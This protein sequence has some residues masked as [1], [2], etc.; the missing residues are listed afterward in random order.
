MGLKI[1]RSKGELVPTAEELPNT[2]A[3]ALKKFNALFGSLGQFFVDRDSELQQIKM[4]LLTKEHVLLQGTPGTAKSLLARSVFQNVIGA[5]RYEVQFSKFMSEDY[6]FGPVNIK[7]L[8]EDG[9]I[10][11]NTKGTIVDSDFAFIDE[12]FDGSD[13]LLRSM[14]EILNERTFT[15][16]SKRVECPLHTAILTSNYTRE[17]EATGAILDRILFKSSVQPISDTDGRMTM[18]KAALDKKNSC[19][20]EAI[21]QV[22]LNT[23]AAFVMSGDVKVSNDVLTMY[24]TVVRE[25]IRQMKTK[26][27]SD[28][29]CVKMLG[30]L[31]ASAVTHGRSDVLME[32][33]QSISL[34][35]VPTGDNMAEAAFE[36]V[37]ARTVVTGKKEQEEM[38]GLKKLKIRFEKIL[39]TE[40]APDEDKNSVMKVRELQK[41]TDDDLRNANFTTQNLKDELDKLGEAVDAAVKAQ[42]EAMN[43]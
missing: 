22:D 7:K 31:K 23:L 42:K 15:R 24:D 17:E 30:V 25:Y 11:H 4:A 12:F 41:F 33:I 9:E 8:R 14:L 1:L 20:L 2:Q 16:N 43:L 27:V 34:A 37:Y 6:V 5:S 29:T 28:R 21:K 35:L 10:A 40:F 36:N 38:I 39:K 3:T 32:D 18:Y 26:N 13:V 19:K